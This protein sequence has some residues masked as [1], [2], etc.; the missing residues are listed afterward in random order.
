MGVDSRRRTHPDRLA[1]LAHGWRVSVRLRQRSNRHEDGFLACSQR[2][3]VTAT[4]TRPVLRPASASRQTGHH[5]TS[6][7]KRGCSR[8]ISCKTPEHGSSRNAFGSALTTDVP[9]EAHARQPESR[10]EGPWRSGSRIQHA[11]NQVGATSRS[12]CR[13]RRLSDQPQSTARVVHDARVATPSARRSRP[14][15]RGHAPNAPDREPVRVV[16]RERRVPEAHHHIRDLAR[17][18]ATGD[19]AE[20]DRH[21]EPLP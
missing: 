10:N 11:P 13:R 19:A 7:R 14:S 9:H 4:I 20:Q 8:S 16:E 17:L 5:M 15:R 6:W 18:R 12:G 21:L 2:H 3:A 1:N